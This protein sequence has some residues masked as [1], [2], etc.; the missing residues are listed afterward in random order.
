MT[1]NIFTLPVAVTVSRETA[2]ELEAL[3]RQWL[4]EYNDAVEQLHVIGSYLG[5]KLS[6]PHGERFVYT[7]KPRE[8]EHTIVVIAYN[9]NGRLVTRGG[10]D[11]NT[12]K[13]TTVWETLRIVSV[14]IA[15]RAWKLDDEVVSS[16]GYYWLG[17]DLIGLASVCHCV[18]SDQSRPLRDDER[19]IPGNWLSYTLNHYERAVD[20]RQ[21]LRDQKEQR[22]AQALAK[23]LLLDIREEI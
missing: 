14:Y 8:Y 2:S 7:I 17:Y 21:E 15:P 13:N 12:G 5:T 10:Y 18:L 4:D 20:R 9:A 11:T 16:G 23:L 22:D 1:K 19:F 6:T 3:R